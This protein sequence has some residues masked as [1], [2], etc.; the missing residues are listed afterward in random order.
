M[1]AIFGFTGPGDE[2]LQL[3]MREALAHRG[4]ESSLVHTGLQ[5][6][7]AYGFSHDDGLLE[8]R[9]AGL[10]C[11]G[12]QALALAGFVTNESE[13][14]TLFPPCGD[15][16]D[17][18]DGAV[19]GDTYGQRVR[20]LAPD[21]LLPT[22]LRAYR[23]EGIDCVHRLRGAFVVA[24]L[25]G[26]ML[27]LARDGAGARTLFHA[28][29]EGRVFFAAE[30]KGIWLLPGFS[31]KIRPA[32]IAQYLSFS[33]LPGTG[34]MLADIHE[35]L[36]GHVLTFR[37]GQEPRVHRFLRFEESAGSL[38]EKPPTR[39]E[40]DRF[41]ID[42]FRHELRTA[43]R[44]RWVEQEPVG[45]FL[46]GGI[47]SSVVV[48]ELASQMTRP[49]KTYAVHFGAKYPNELAFA[50]AVAE[51]LGTDH[52]EI[53]VRP[54]SFLPKLRRIIWH[55]DDPIG[56]PVTVPNYALAERVSR[57]TKMVF[58]GEG[59]D[60]CFGG[61]KNIPMMLQHWYGGINRGE[62]FLEPLFAGKRTGAFVT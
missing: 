18:Q 3:K 30:P 2:T 31:R 57:E 7:L 1:S 5:G 37:E 36:P 49:L 28:R 9:G 27:H 41:W 60:P 17:R 10:F 51:R 59:G 26:S 48:A 16:E 40:E 44:D 43:I 61:P 15:D 62:G 50:R 56:D 53:L 58:N 46:S 23:R 39:E 20:G 4:S 19:I 55:L 29:H 32:A 42:R 13:L 21:H 33:F 35:L 38:A 52:Q 12:G 22:L 14:R 24:L 54:K 25:D 11:D 6:T 47:D 34:T 8:R 45:A